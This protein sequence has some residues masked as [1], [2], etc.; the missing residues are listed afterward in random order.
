MR[1]E[2]ALKEQNYRIPIGLGQAQRK[3]KINEGGRYYRVQIIHL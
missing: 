1:Q 3:S 2:D